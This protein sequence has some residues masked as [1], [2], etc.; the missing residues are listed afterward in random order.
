[1]CRAVGRTASPGPW[2]V[3]KHDLSW[4]QNKS[5]PVEGRQGVLQINSYF[6]T[7]NEM[8]CE[9]RLQPW[10]H[11]KPFPCE[12]AIL[13]LNWFFPLPIISSAL[14]VFGLA[15][16][17]LSLNSQLK[18]SLSSLSKLFLI[19]IPGRTG[20]SSVSLPEYH[21][22]FLLNPA[23]E[24]QGWKKADSY[25]PWF[26]GTFWHLP[27]SKFLVKNPPKSFY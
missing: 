12:R 10:C 5:R 23:E 3:G 21:T 24:W 15:N 18:A 20:H 7:L 26:P 17:S 2:M 25:L 22:Y 27:W 1:M 11:L 4:H 19:I 16:S 14:T 8:F 6:L 13:C 9:L